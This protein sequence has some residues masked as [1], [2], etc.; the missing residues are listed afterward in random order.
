MADIT[1]TVLIDWDNDGSVLAGSPTA[2]EDVSARVLN[3]RTGQSFSY[4]RDT[5]RSQSAS[6]PA[7]VQIEL[8]NVSRDYMPDYSS[9]PLY[10]DLGPGKPV[11]IIATHS[12]TDYHLFFGFI[13]GYEIDPF[14]EKRSVML[15]CVDSLARIAQTKV[16]TE[17]YPSIQT[18]AAINAILDSAGW[19]EDLRDI[20]AGATTMRYWAEDGVDAWTAIQTCVSTEGNPAIAFVDPTTGNLVFRDRHHRLLRAASI[21]SQATISDTGSEPL[22]SD[23]VEYNVGFRDLINTCNFKVQER[24]PW[25]NVVWETD[26]TFSIAAGTTLTLLVTSDEPFFEAEVPNEE[27]EDYEVLSGDVTISLSRTSGKTTEL[28]IFGNSASYVTGMRLRAFKCAVGREYTVSSVSADSVTKYGVASPD[29]ASTPKWAG[30]NDAK[31]IGDIY[32]AQRGERLPVFTVTVKGAN[33]TR[34][35]QI[36]TRKLGDMVTLVEAQTATNHTHYVEKIEHQI[37]QAGKLHAIR[38]GCERT[39]VAT[40]TQFTFGVAGAGFDQGSFGLS[41][42]DDPDT[43][44]ILDGGANHRLDEGKLAT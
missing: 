4:G 30:V 40:G 25:W 32:V 7:Q 17:C 34:K 27:E 9:S 42:Y 36:L 18:G 2:G 24:E 12:G 8:N 37:T 33:D 19:P 20:D 10:G 15:T 44:F 22:F 11:L 23:P 13:D 43:V 41:G 5:A 29:E 6:K 26:S 31:A 16:S 14:R 28:S 39:K 38:L 3:V 1:Y 21:T 35:T